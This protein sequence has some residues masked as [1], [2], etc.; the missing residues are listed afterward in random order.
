VAWTERQAAVAELATRATAARAQGNV[1][2][3]RLA[4]LELDAERRRLLLLE[5]QRARLVLRAPAAGV[6]VTP[7]LHER[8]GATIAAGD[9]LIE[10]WAA[11]PVHTRIV[12]AQRNAG[13]VAVDSPLRIRFPAA[14]SRT[15]STAITRLEAATDGG[16]VIAWAALPASYT[17]HLRPGMHGRAR[18]HTARVSLA[19]AAAR[20]LRHTLRGDLFL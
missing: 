16:A 11:G 8:V 2:A 3:A 7:L 5:E 9:S 20:K 10:I 12:V 19:G 4:E 14:P 17:G 13:G 18:I 6:V 15:W 1:A